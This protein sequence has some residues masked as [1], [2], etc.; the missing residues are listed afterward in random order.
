VGAVSLSRS[1]LVAT[2]FGR[3]AQ[4]YDESALIQRAVSERLAD[5]VLWDNRP[6]GITLEIGCGT[7]ILTNLLA[8][9]APTYVA[10]DISPA[11]VDV[12]RTR[13][14]RVVPL[15]V[16][17]ELPCFTASFDTI[18][19]SLA[20]H[21]FSNLKDTLHHLVACLKPGGRLYFSSF[22]SNT[23][24]EWRTAH[25]LENAP[26]GLMD[27]VVLGVLKDALPSMGERSIREEWIHQDVA[28]ARDFLHHL[29]A[30]GAHL[31]HAGHTPLPPST[32]RRVMRR[33]DQK[34]HLSHQIIYGMYEKPLKWTGD[35]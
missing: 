34:P 15:V 32:M 12:T 10:S 35:E 2:T 20:L 3:S 16:D 11:M 22:G 25:A 26:C 28:S 1:Q 5:D 13:Y 14:E 31:P 24:Y 9:H 4:T 19:T 18:V 29:K 23:Y 30:I 7:G 27:F 17:A 6:L 33:F 8:S 21:W